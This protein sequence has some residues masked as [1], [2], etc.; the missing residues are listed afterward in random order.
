[1]IFM[2]F[3]QC[4][5]Y[6]RHFASFVD[7]LI[8]TRLNFRIIWLNFRIIWLNF[9]NYLTEFK[10]FLRVIFVQF[11]PCN[12]YYGYFVSFVGGLLIIWLKYLTELSDFE[13]FDWNIWLKYLTELSDFEL[14]DWFLKNFKSDICAILPV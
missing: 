7:G 14:F 8:I 13:L 3:W 6:Y 9:M 5:N 4:N 10:E 11:C 12:N 2:Q 1:M